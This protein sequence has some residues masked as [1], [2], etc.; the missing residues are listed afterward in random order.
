MERELRIYEMSDAANPVSLARS[1]L[2]NERFPTE[3]A[4][5]RARRAVSLKG[6]KYSNDELWSFAMLPDAPA[7]SGLPSLLRFS[8]RTSAVLTTVFSAEGDRRHPAVRPAH[9]LSPRGHARDA[10]MR[11]GAGRAQEG[12][13]HPTA[14]AP[15]ATQRGVPVA[16]AVGTLSAG[17]SGDLVCGGGGGRRER[18]GLAPERWVPPPPSPRAL[19]A[20]EEQAP[21]VG[22]VP[23]E[24]R[25]VSRKRRHV[26]R[27][28]PEVP[29]RRPRVPRRHPGV[30]RRRRQAPQRHAGVPRRQR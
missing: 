5:T 21:A 1:R 14:G 2:L 8:Q 16:R 25:S 30:S 18:W 12:E 7:V 6:G 20:A 28:R 22:R 26:P 24:H 23:Q 19:Q 4:A 17:D 10:A 3:Y 29:H 13:K 15:G 9:A 27:R 11:A